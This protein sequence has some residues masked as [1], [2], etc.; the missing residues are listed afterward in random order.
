[1]KSKERLCLI[2]LKYVPIICAFLMLLHIVTLIIGVTLCIAELM[3][4]TIVTIMVLTWSYLFKFCLT[5]RL[6]SLYTIIVLWC[7]YYQRFIGFGEYLEFLRIA[8]LYFGILLFI[9]ITF[10]C[11]KDYKKLIAKHNQ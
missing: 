7:C 10:K 5:H 8:F 9:L 6:A 3:V 2:L 1:M 11:V 4:I